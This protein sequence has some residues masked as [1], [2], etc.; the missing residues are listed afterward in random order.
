MLRA[1]SSWVISL[2]SCILLIAA[3]GQP[4]FADNTNSGTA[5]PFG[6]VPWGS[7]PD[8]IRQTLEKQGYV[9]QKV[10]SDGDLDFTGTVNGVSAQLFAFLTPDRRLVKT[11]VV[12]LTSDDEAIDFYHTLRE[13]LIAKYG[14]PINS[15]ED[16]SDPYSDSDD[17]SDK[18]VAISV[19]DGHVASFWTYAD[20][21]GMYIE[22]TKAL[23]VSVS[24]ESAGWPAEMK[25]RQDA[26]TSGF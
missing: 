22:V 21:T 18:Q 4:T 10:D 17:D 14:D 9:F 8:V 1:Q 2:G 20:T 11:Q 16:Y 26:S 24:Y 15:F 6:G 23:N 5:H 7:K 25:R 12:C 13:S 19:G 3:L